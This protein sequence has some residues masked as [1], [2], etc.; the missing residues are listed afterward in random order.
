MKQAGTT[1]GAERGRAVFGF[2]CLQIMLAMTA[3]VFDLSVR[4]GDKLVT[5]LAGLLAC[6]PLSLYFGLV[7]IFSARH[8][9]GTPGRRRPRTRRWTGALICWAIIFSVALTNWPVRLAFVLS[10]SALEQLA[11][12]VERGGKMGRQAERAGFFHVAR[13]ERTLSGSVCLWLDGETGFVRFAPRVSNQNFEMR[14]VWYG[15]VLSGTWETGTWQFG[16][17]D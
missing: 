2:I 14:N 13:T 8:D 11:D 1:I 9:S 10:R 4:G 15:D 7:W 16:T 3:F 6:G 12:R 5:G 17:V